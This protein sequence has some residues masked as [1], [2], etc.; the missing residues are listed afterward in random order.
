MA[1]AERWEKTTRESQCLNIGTSLI[2][3]RG[4]GR[5]ANSR[6]RGN[7]TEPTFSP[8]EQSASQSIA[9]EFG[10]LTIWCPHVTCLS[11]TL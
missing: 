11:I 2:G 7:V 9:S 6:V 8:V 4:T 10:T 5:R 3:H 1:Y